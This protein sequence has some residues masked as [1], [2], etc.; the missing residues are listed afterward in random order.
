MTYSAL[1]AAGAMLSACSML[2]GKKA[3][4]TTSVPFSTISSSAYSGSLKNW[5]DK[6]QPVMCALIRSQSQWSY[7]FQPADSGTSTKHKIVHSEDAIAPKDEYFET[8]QLLLA[9]RLIQAPD[10]AERDQI[11]TAEKVTV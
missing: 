4:D 6:A 11:F 7:W 3:E 2:F 1:V 10:S 8:R 9:T 5:D